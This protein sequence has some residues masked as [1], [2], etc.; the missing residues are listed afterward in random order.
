MAILL[1]DVGAH[2]ASIEGMAAVA[3][4]LLDRLHAGVDDPFRWLS[5]GGEQRGDQDQQAM[6]A[7]LTLPCT[8]EEGPRR[9]HG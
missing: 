5:A 3:N 2:V 9:A 1:L 7:H 4:P 8:A 6:N